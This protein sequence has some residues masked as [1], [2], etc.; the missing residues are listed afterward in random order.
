MLNRIA[1]A[2][3]NYPVESGAQ[4]I[5]LCN[6]LPGVSYFATDVDPRSF[7]KNGVDGTWLGRAE[8]LLKAPAELR[9]GQGAEVSFTLPVKVVLSEQDGELLVTA[10]DF[11][12]DEE[13]QS[14]QRQV[15]EFG[16]PKTIGWGPFEGLV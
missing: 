10:F 14:S 13:E 15:L 9:P 7:E 4:W 6:N 5:A 1:E 12:F 16:P 2:V 11:Y 8:L 3:V